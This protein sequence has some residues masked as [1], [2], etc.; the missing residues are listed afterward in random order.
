MCARLARPG[1]TACASTYV[2]SPEGLSKE[3]WE[4]M[5]CLSVSWRIALSGTMSACFVGPF[6]VGGSCI[7]G[8][9]LLFLF[10]TAMLL[11]E[12]YSARSLFK[13]SSPSRC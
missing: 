3:L 6:S 1:G 8:W 5:S 9:L 12:L 11:D 13:R 4:L 10:G 2:P 7:V